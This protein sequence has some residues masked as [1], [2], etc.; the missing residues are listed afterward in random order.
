[1]RRK[2]L[3]LLAAAMLLTSGCGHTAKTLNG[4]AVTYANDP[5]PN[6]VCAFSLSEV[7]GWHNMNITSVH[8]DARYDAPC[9]DPA[10]TV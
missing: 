3:A 10:N 4:Y 6:F 9:N 2:G 7:N 8:R 5:V 1:M